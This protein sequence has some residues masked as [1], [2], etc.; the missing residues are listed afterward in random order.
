MDWLDK[1]ESYQFIGYEYAGGFSP[2]SPSAMA[3]PDNK[4]L[5]IFGMHHY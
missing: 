5:V 4:V 1:G 2:I 3:G